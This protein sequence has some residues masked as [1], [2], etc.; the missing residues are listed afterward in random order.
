M[1]PM[2]DSTTAFLLWL[3]QFVNP[4]VRALLKSRLHGLMSQDVLNL[5]FRGRKS[6]R[7]YETPV[8]YVQDGRRLRVFTDSPW[9][10]NLR[11]AGVPTRV[12]LRGRR[13]DVS[14]TTHSD[15]GA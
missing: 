1:N 10:K 14:A 12:D 9:W 6:G 3:A 4:F 7:W 2:V 5:H 15:G 11:G 8:S 13:I